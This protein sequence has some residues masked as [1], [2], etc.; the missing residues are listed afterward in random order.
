M[1]KLKMDAHQ[2]R[3][4]YPPMP[5]AVDESLKQTLSSLVNGRE[6]PVMK[7]KVSLGL[8]LALVLLL[9]TISAAIALTQSDLLGHLFGGGERVPGGM[10]G[11]LRQLEETV[12][13]EDVS[14][15]LNEY[16]FDGEKLHLRWTV[17]GTSGRQIMVT[18]SPFQ[19]DKEGATVEDETSFQTDDHAWAYVLNGE[20]DGT[21]MPG[22]VSNYI[23][24][25][26]TQDGDG[27]RPF[28]SGETVTVTG[29]LYLWEI[30]NPPVLV[31]TSAMSGYGGRA[32]TVGPE[33]MEREDVARLRRLPVGRNGFCDLEYFA[34]TGREDIGVFN[35][36]ESEKTYEYLG[37]AKPQSV[38]PVQFSILLNT[39]SIKQAEPVQTT[40]EMDNFTLEITRLA[41]RQTGGTLELK[42]YPKPRGAWISEESPL[43][44]DLVVLD[45][46]SLVFLNGSRSYGNNSELIDNTEYSYV[47]Y[48]ISLL[49]VSGE[50]PAAILIAPGERK[51]DGSYVYNLEEA[52]RV[53]LR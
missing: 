9:I 27:N 29:N 35:A 45:A 48:E 49:P 25:A 11:T 13:A 16:L 43:V 31:D 33:E 34:V 41:Y 6:K 17:E 20:A 51:Y 52:V 36:K 3:A 5:G 32:G 23:T 53:D 22:S 37:W 26:N 38:L 40:F 28:V 18:M 1:K 4:L 42:V 7:R 24:F 12:K 50:M 2:L 21:A 44:R 47:F 8:V 10:E 46:G 15:T 19:I 14:V 30:L 39:Q